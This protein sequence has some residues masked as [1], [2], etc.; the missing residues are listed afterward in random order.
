[1]SATVIDVF[2]IAMGLMDEISSTGAS[3][4]A[5]TAEYRTRTL[6]IINN[7]QQEL[8]P[9]SD[10]YAVA[11]A[12]KRPVLARLAVLTDVIG[13]DDYLTQTVLPYGLAAALLLDENPAVAS[14]FQ[15]RYEELKR[16]ARSVPAAFS[17]IEDVYGGIEHGQ[18]SRW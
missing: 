3:E 16:L 15:Q 6:R 10:S 11:A 1:M 9:L 7:L 17:A 2:D 18:F 13:L 12:G 5:D 14:F 4:S 8:Y